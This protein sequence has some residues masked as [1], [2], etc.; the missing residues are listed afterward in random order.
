ME[1]VAA[2]Q[3]FR[4]AANTQHTLE[5]SELYSSFQTYMNSHF[6]SNVLIFPTAYFNAIQY[7]TIQPSMIG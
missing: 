3:C 2:H 4:Q 5:V 7:N 1:C 6:N